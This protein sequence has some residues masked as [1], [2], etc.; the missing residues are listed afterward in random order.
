MNPVQRLPP[1]LFTFAIWAGGE[2]DTTQALDALYL[3][4]R[5]GDTVLPEPPQKGAR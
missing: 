5:A 4:Q 1:S 3:R 2:A